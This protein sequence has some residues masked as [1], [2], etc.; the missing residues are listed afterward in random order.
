MPKSTDEL[1][2]WV[3]QQENSIKGAATASGWSVGDELP[4]APSRD[5]EDVFN[6]TLP[7]KVLRDLFLLQICNNAFLPVT[8]EILYQ[9]WITHNKLRKIS[10][11]C[12]P[13]FGQNA[14]S[15]RFVQ[16]PLSMQDSRCL[17]SSKQVSKILLFLL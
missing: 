9:L 7:D 5:D 12:L 8:N 14:S 4:R 1:N 11:L 3:C 17:S 13:V 15:Y 16:T 6:S 2:W 10:F